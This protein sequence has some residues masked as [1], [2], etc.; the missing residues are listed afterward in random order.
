MA[1]TDVDCDVAYHGARG[2]VVEALQELQTGGLATA[3]GSYQRHRLPG[4]YGKVQ[5]LED[6]NGRS[7]RIAELHSLVANVAAHLL[8]QA[9]FSGAD[10]VTTQHNRC[11]MDV[12]REK[13]FRMPL[14]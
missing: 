13:M 8:Q 11:E 10:D 9:R 6:L 5:A 4:L 3:T 1:A 7:R 2:G 12:Q 14:F